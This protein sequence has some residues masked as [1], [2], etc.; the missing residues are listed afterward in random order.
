ML[1]T[2]LLPPICESILAGIAIHVCSGESGKSI[3]KGKTTVF[4]RDVRVNF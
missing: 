2:W 3:T 4:H 1:Q